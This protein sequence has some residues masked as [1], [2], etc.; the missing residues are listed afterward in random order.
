MQAIYYGGRKKL[1][2]TYKNLRVDWIK[3][4]IDR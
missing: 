2:G 1:N 3:M 4:K